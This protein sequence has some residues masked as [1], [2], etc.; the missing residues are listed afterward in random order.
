[1]LRP[2]TNHKRQIPKFHV[3]DVVYRARPQGLEG[4]Y[5]VVFV[6]TGYDPTKYTLCLAKETGTANTR[7]EVEET[8]LRDG[9]SVLTSEVP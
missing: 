8:E 5:K 1:M 6:H 9:T 4:P 2:N 3:A 7:D